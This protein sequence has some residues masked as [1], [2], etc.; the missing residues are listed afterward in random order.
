[1]GHDQFFFVHVMKT[2]G[3][4]FR[5]HIYENFAPGEV[6]PDRRVAKD[7]AQMA[8]EYTL[9]ARM[10]DLPRE[11][12]RKT[13]LFGGHFPFCTVDMLGLPLETLTILRDPVDRIVSYLRRRQSSAQGARARAYGPQS[14]RGEGRT[15]EE[16]YD[17]PM[18]FP[19]FI[20]NHQV[21]QFALTAADQPESY[22]DVLAVDDDRLEVARNN[23]DR[24]DLIGLTA[25][26]DEF[27][28]EVRERY[29]WTI[30]PVES[31]HV[32]GRDTWEPSPEFRARIASDNAADVEF[33]EY[34]RS[35]HDQRRSA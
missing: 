25:H 27:L 11:Q 2:A 9:I 1:M 19:M 7:P 18:V 34:A 12:R 17:D 32:A 8:D 26:F 30:T 20:H 13:R 10:L 29:G 28:G 33:Y 3:G 14:L 23:L 35:L 4:T 5:Q 16:I 24:V 21:K 22:L 15:P 31:Q 6:Y